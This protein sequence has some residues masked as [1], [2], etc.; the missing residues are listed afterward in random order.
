M[1]NGK[2]GSLPPK[3]EEVSE[4]N[5]VRLKNKQEKLR[6]KKRKLLVANILNK[7]IV[8]SVG[9]MYYKE[10]IVILL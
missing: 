3:H 8:I 9:L 7:A 5:K 6:K 10:L 1:L 4:L 2:R